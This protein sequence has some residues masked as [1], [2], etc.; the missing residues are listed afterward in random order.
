LRFST[1]EIVAT[2]EAEVA[3]NF[4]SSFHRANIDHILRYRKDDTPDKEAYG[5]RRSAV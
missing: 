3:I 5:Q 1:P 2:P 4:Y